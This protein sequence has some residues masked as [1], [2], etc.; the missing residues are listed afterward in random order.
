MTN[1]S[2]VLKKYLPESAQDS[3]VAIADDVL[4]DG[5]KKHHASSHG[6]RL[7][8]YTPGES[9]SLG[10]LR[11][12]FVY[13]RD[14]LSLEVEESQLP[15]WGVNDYSGE[16]KCFLTN[17]GQAS[18]F[19][20]LTYCRSILNVTSIARLSPVYIGARE[21][22]EV[23]G[24]K[25][26][27]PGDAKVLWLC[28]SSFFKELI[29][30]L[31][32]FISGIEVVLIDTTCWSL[33][34]SLLQELMEMCADKTIILMRSISKLDMAGIEY[35]SLGSLVLLTHDDVEEKSAQLDK[36]LKITGGAPSLDDIP[37]YLFDQDYHRFLSSRNIEMEKITGSI[38]EMAKT[39]TYPELV[40]T[41][42]PEHKK[43][44][45]IY[46]HSHEFGDGK[47]ILNLLSRTFQIYEI[48]V[49]AIAS[50]GFEETVISAFKENDSD[51]GILRI[52]PGRGFDRDHA[53]HKAVAYFFELLTHYRMKFNE[54]E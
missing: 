17:S 40:T 41:F 53:I 4:I 27:Q 49:K 11:A 23:L 48:P 3:S 26:E 12:S 47:E 14:S 34:S 37:P 13:K 7:T 15:L 39:W 43:Y 20:G 32:K 2:F 54:R 18:L 22:A 5:I 44:F 35:G 42:F 46:L 52:S 1:L 10:N 24:M 19:A 45:F 28:S 16:K 6:R 21:G 8:S 9:F 51:V 29:I 38:Q 25:F 33:D 31:R 50:F 30:Y 36:I